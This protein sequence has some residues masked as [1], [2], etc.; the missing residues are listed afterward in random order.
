MA[1]NPLLLG[2]DSGGSK[3]HVLLTDAEGRALGS[4]TA[5]ASNYQYV[6][7]ARA[8][9]TMDDA[10]GQ[11]FD[12][13]SL[14]RRPVDF[15]GFGF[16]G[17]DTEEELSRM[18]VWV[19][20]QQW[21]RS[22]VIVNDGMLPI[23]A[24]CPNGEGVGVVAGTGAIIWAA[25]RLPQPRVAR[26]SGWGYLMGDEGGGYW[27]AGQALRHVARAEDGRGPSTLL[28][29]R[30]LQHWELP[31]AR[32]LILH[33]YGQRW[34]PSE[35]ALL[36]PVLLACAE[37][38]DPV[39]LSIAQAGA[40]ELALAA[41]VAMQQVGLRPPVTVAYTGSLLVKNA[42]YRALFAQAIAQRIGH[43]EL[44][45]VEQPVLGAVAA[46]RLLQQGALTAGCTDWCAV[47]QDVC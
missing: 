42:L 4:G 11:A 9:Q 35:I 37:E 45:A 36:A 23:Y 29:G 39:A 31:N 38:G 41:A 17:A 27:L 33:L 47:V 3:T 22:F 44:H 7:E 15:A 16:G 20:R 10:I 19:T 5:G 40:D 32:A 1:S 6:G 46:A 43:A 34:E 12:Q 13:A 21:A 8:L 25:S 26:T 28:T 30:V 2:V 14:A 18:S 24:A